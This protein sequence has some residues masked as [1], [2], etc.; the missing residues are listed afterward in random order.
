MMPVFYL[1]S[2][3][4]RKIF[5]FV[6]FMAGQGWAQQW[7][8]VQLPVG[9]QPGSSWTASNQAHSLAVRG[10][11]VYLV[12]YNAVD[13]NSNTGHQ[14]Y[15]IKYNGTEWDSVS[16]RI[17]YMNYNN[18]SWRRHNWYPSCAVD[19]SGALHVVWETNDFIESSEGVSIY[20]IVYRRLSQGA[21]VPGLSEKPVNITSNSSQG[22]SWRPVIACG[23]DT[24]VHIAWQDNQQGTFKIFY[25]SS[26]GGSAWSG[27]IC[28]S[29]QGIYAGF[30]S[31]AMSGNQPAVVWQDF[32]DGRNQIYFKKYSASGWGT[33]S[34]ISQSSYGAFA[35]CLAGDQAGNLY[36]AWEDLRDGNFEIYYRR[37][38][39]QTQA[40]GNVIR[41]TEDPYYSRQPFLL[42]Q[43]DSTVNLFWA[44]DRD[45]SYEIYQRKSVSN[46]WQPET[47][48][49]A[50]NGSSSLNPSAAV[51]YPGNLHLV[52]SDFSGWDAVNPEIFYMSG[53]Y[54]KKSP[55]ESQS[56]I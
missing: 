27:N 45:G 32:R 18:V 6:L 49:T 31:I 40:W 8:S 10:D 52:W 21:W 53:V 23:S 13:I 41:L 17:G 29:P 25:I 28:L 55:A 22:Y 12:W 15:F 39:V 1:R 2:F 11:T 9:W 48:L 51:D 5:L 54:S 46:I 16:T 35:P 30:P 44:D 34:A 19:A 47:T 14:I 4:V 20:D 56:V 38:S 33:D 50:F 42:C 26:I 3:A 24:S 37:F 43:G 36:A 7:S